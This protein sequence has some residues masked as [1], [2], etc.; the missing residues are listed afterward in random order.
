[1]SS[2]QLH[3]KIETSISIPGT[4]IA[5]SMLSKISHFRSNIDQIKEDNLDLERMR[6]QYII[7]L[8]Q[9][10]EDHEV[11]R[12]LY[13]NLKQKLDHLNYALEQSNLQHPSTST[14]QSHSSKEQS[15]T[16]TP[17]TSSTTMST[18]PTVTTQLIKTTTYNVSKDQQNQIQ[19]KHIR[20]T[21]ITPKFLVQRRK[22]TLMKAFSVD[23]IICYVCYNKTGS[24]IAFSTG[25]YLFVMNSDDG[26]LIAEVELP[27]VD[28]VSD[29]HCRSLVFSPDGNQIAL[30]DPKNLIHIV[31]IKT[32]KVEATLEGHTEE[33]SSL[34]FDQDGNHII[35]GS[36]DGNIIIWDA[37]TYKEIRRITIAEETGPEHKTENA[38]VGI[39]ASSDPSFYAVASAKG[40]VTILSLEFEKLGPAF[41]AHTHSL[42]G[43][44]VSPLDEYIATVSQ[45]NTVKVWSFRVNAN[46]KNTFSNHKDY[47]LTAAFN[48]QAQ[49]L[50]TGSKDQTI[51]LWNYKKGSELSV[52]E[53]HTNT[54]FSI[55]HHPD[56]DRFV[57]V[58][59]DSLV[60][61]WDY[62]D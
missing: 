21:K 55:A 40:T 44:S 39:A 5:D 49:I 4:K 19:S 57:S 62:T 29:I 26:K 10:Q 58:G 7:H 9:C 61:F 46:L 48:S 38:I 31:N 59:G 20:E 37:K 45:D 17:S 50:V 1:M 18:T 42:M 41:E 35:S 54:V 43:I 36:F 15:R 60:C 16:I 3:A 52:I 25:S 22:V 30:A 13:K 24:Q 34:L 27:K 14:N 33:V 2:T 51:R 32:R 53:A 8:Q 47:T 6:D 56:K 12:Q 23:G 28:G 11:L